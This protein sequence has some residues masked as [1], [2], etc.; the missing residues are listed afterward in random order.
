M[1][2]SLIYSLTLMML[3]SSCAGD[4]CAVYR[5]VKMSQDAASTLL[6]Q[7]RDAAQETAANNAYHRRYCK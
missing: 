6:A 5:P 4:F 3:L 2:R 1:K 7:D